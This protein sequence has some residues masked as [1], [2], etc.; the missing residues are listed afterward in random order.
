MNTIFRWLAAVVW[1]TWSG[2]SLAQAMYRIK[3]LGY[4]GG[5]TTSVPTVV[6]LNEADRVAGTACNAN[7]DK[8]AFLWKND[9]S[10]M[11]D[12]GPDGVGSFSYATAINASG[13]VSGGMADHDDGAGDKFAFVSLGDGT[14]AT[15]IPNNTDTLPLFPTAMNDVGQ[16]T[17]A[18][19]NSGQTAFLWSPGGPLVRDMGNLGGESSIGRA[20]NN[21]GQVAGSSQSDADG[22]G[23]TRL[24]GKMTAHPF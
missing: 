7:G 10:P 2:T 16:L 19:G 1:I 22:G 23:I 14:P 15:R 11:V 24:S 21:S 20:I 8:H 13:L 18:L 3:P 9:G 4:L 5:C 12:L 6:G 17:G